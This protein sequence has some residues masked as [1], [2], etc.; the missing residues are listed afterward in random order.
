ML[1]VAHFATQLSD[2]VTWDFHQTSRVAIGSGRLVEMVDVA[3]A[4]SLHEAA[5]FEFIKIEIK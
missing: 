3:L 1:T 4:P 5:N 2:W